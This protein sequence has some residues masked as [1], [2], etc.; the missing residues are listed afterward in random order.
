[1]WVTTK[2][3]YQMNDAGDYEL[4]SM[5]GYEYEGPVA[6]CGGGPSD[7]QKQAAAS[8]AQLNQQDMQTQQQMLQMY[9]DQYAKV[10][11]FE[12]NRMNN[13]LPYFNALTDYTNGT[14][15]QAFKPAYAA[16]SQRISANGA[17]PSGFGQQLTSDLDAQKARSFDS[18][19]TNNLA[20][21]DTAKTNAAAALVGQQQLSNPLGWSQAVTQG[22]SAIMNAP[23]ASPGIGGMLGGMAGAALSNPAIPF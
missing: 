19:M 5:E 6:M 2:A 17:L 18:G 13:G 23:L 8:Q 14:N 21:N 20:L 16:L 9:K 15:A 11:P 7:S 4:V 12:T 10:N 1:M 3:V 22:N